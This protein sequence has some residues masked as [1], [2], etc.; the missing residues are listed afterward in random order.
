MIA[1]IDLYRDRFGAG[2]ICRTLGATAGGL[3]TARG[4]RAAKT[5]PIAA[6]SMRDVLLLGEIKRPHEADYGVYGVRK[7]FAV[8]GRAG[9]QA[10]RPDR[11]SDAGRRLDRCHP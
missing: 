7:M 10:G 4:Y 3:I 8:M 1:H 6:R 9:W 11:A 5:G 2:P